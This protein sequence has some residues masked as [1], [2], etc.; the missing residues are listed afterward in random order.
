MAPQANDYEW[1]CHI[2]GEQQYARL[3]DERCARIIEAKQ[4]KDLVEIG[5][6]QI[7]CYQQLVDSYKSDEKSYKKIFG[8]KDDI[9]R[10][11]KLQLEIMEG[12]LLSLRIRSHT[13]IR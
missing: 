5:E 12:K 11:Q 10:M 9:I 1:L 6:K 4:Q 7:E 3:I 2:G 13:Y 8:L